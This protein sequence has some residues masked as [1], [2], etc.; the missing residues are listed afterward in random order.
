REEQVV[1]KGL[2]LLIL[3]LHDEFLVMNVF[4]RDLVV[5]IDAAVF[6]GA[7]K[8]GLY[9]HWCI[10]I[11]FYFDAALAVIQLIFYFIPVRA[12]IETKPAPFHFFQGVHVSGLKPELQ[13]AAAVVSI[14]I[15]LEFLVCDLRFRRLFLTWMRFKGCCHVCLLTKLTNS[16]PALT[17]I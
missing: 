15:D 6:P 17:M 8:P 13:L 5:R 2:R 9:A 7:P 14:D 1:A 12:R 10:L 11:E 16:D 3:V 4:D